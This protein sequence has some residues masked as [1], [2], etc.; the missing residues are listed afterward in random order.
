MHCGHG[1]GTA[2][3]SGLGLDSQNPNPTQSGPSAFLREPRSEPHAHTTES[4][5]GSHVPLREIQSEPYAPLHPAAHSTPQFM[6]VGSGCLSAS[7]NYNPVL[8]LSSWT[9]PSSAVTSASNQEDAGP[10]SQPPSYIPFSERQVFQPGGRQDGGEPPAKRPRYFDNDNSEDS[11]EEDSLAEAFDPETFYFKKNQNTPDRIVKYVDRYF[12]CLKREARKALARA[13]P[14]PDIPPL[15][16]PKMDDVIMDF[17]GASFPTKMENALKRIQS[18]IS[19]GDR[20]DP[21]RGTGTGFRPRGASA[22]GGCTGHNP[23]VPRAHWQR[24]KLYFRK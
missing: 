18:C 2:T 7:W 13:H 21:A 22:S 9:T 20:V 10:S 23:E 17:V 11:A 16:C 4:Q 5:S 12:T 15:Q 24:I 1:A 6:G 3:N 19:S 8:A 14:L